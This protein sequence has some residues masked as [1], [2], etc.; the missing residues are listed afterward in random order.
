MTDRYKRLATPASAVVMVAGVVTAVVTPSTPDTTAS[1]ARVIAF[2]QAHHTVAY[3]AAISLAYAAAAGVLF[4][5]S[6]AGYLRTRGSQVLA[7][8]T[9]V[10]AA[11]FAAGSLVA[12]GALMAANDGPG[13][14]TPDIARTLNI[15]QNDLFAP[16]MFAGLAIAILSIGVASLRTNAL[17]KALGIITTIVGVVGLSGI[18]SWFAFMAC[19][20]L[21]LVIAGYVYQ[22]LGTPTQIT[23]PD[24]P[25]ARTAE[26]TTSENATA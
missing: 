20:P 11:L 15:I 6:V 17:P 16:M 19:A 3:V 24:V 7:A 13:S 23:M 22:R 26:V 21:T 4:F 14:M 18:G 8:T 9:T 1:G 25:T 12:C 5:V 10:G 2:F